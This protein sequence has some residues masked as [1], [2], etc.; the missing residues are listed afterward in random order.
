MVASSSANEADFRNLAHA[1][2]VAR[3]ATIVADGT[4]EFRT[5]RTSS[6]TDLIN[7]FQLKYYQHYYYLTQQ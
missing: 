4:K 6:S 1:N 3:L 5:H 2:K 7:L